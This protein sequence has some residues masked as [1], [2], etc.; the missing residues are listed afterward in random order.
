M[1]VSLT[2]A[3]IW[4]FLS[5]LLFLAGCAP[6][7]PGMVRDIQVFPQD[8]NYY[9]DEDP[10]RLLINAEKQDKLYQEFLERFYMPWNRAAPKFKA[11]E[12]FW[13]L[14]LYR[15][16][17]I[18]S[19]NKLPFV[20]GWIGE[21]EQNSDIQAYPSLHIPAISVTHASMR[22]LPTR[23]PVFYDPQRPGEGF[24]FDY[25]QNTLL[26]AGT[27]LLVT[28]VSRDGQWAMTETDFAAGWIR[29][30]DLAV[31][32]D[33]FKRMYQDKAL[34]GFV[35]DDVPVTRE[36]GM[37]AVS[38][39]VG[40]ALPLALE[41]GDTDLW[42]VLVPVRDHLGQAKIISARVSKSN[43]REMPFSPWQKNFADILNSMM[44]QA[45]GW[46]GLFE[47]RDCSA[48]I[49]DALAGFGFFLPRN[50]S[51]QA[52]AGHA[53]SL[54]GLS[55]RQKKDIITA[56]GQ[57]LL[58]ILYMPGHVM[59]YIGQDPATDTPAVYHTMWGLR[60][61]RPF[62]E[63]GRWIIGRTVITSLEPGREMRMLARPEG[64]LLER[65]SRMVLLNK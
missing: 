21:M 2:L 27:P 31:V 39:R 34:L 55:A 30:H 17:D 13:G 5:V 48:L 52:E 33:N 53:V 24:P 4:F 58:T 7:Q 63:D 51:G 38:G 37:F 59:L 60:T 26:P 36:D 28:H 23:R 50:S 57:P 14:D 56:Q 64:L 47:N 32:D 35:S 43:A 9:I 46:G 12:V 65:L 40:M 1:K 8:A 61:W 45:Y 15:A 49:R 42:R 19:E 20:P 10:A 41:Q 6:K 11:S 18:Y 29:W 44:G 54:E 16:R 3:W 25:M 62:R 22:V